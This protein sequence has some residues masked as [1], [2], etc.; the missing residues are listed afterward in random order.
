MVGSF[1]LAFGLRVGA[2]TV[3]EQAVGQ[4]AA[5]TLMEEH[6]EQGYL[7]ATRGRR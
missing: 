3:M 1:Q 7:D 2:G 5:K 6:E 4:G